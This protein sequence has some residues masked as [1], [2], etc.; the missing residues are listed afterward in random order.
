[1]AAGALTGHVIRGVIK[2]KKVMTSVCGHH[3][4]ANHRQ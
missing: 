2:K 3:D 4:Y 1:M